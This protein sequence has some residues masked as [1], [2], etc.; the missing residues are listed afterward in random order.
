MKIQQ[1]AINA[2]IETAMHVKLKHGYTKTAVVFLNLRYF[3]LGFNFQKDA[4]MGEVYQNDDGTKYEVLA[5]V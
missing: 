2:Q 3:A 1:H 5:L 4:K